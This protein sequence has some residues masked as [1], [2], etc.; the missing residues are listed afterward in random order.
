MISADGKE[1]VQILKRGELLPGALV[2]R[3][4]LFSSSHIKLG[5]RKKMLGFNSLLHKLKF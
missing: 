5:K 4:L 2:D 3:S 1:K